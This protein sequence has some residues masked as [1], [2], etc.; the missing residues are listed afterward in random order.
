MD[1][2]GIWVGSPGQCVC[3]RSQTGEST[4]TPSD[5]QVR[6]KQIC[7][8]KPLNGSKWTKEDIEDYK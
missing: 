5:E 8:V 2:G 4:D 7:E 6:A 3:S 1:D